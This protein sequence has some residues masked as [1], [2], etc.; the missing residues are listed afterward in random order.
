MKPK[1]FEGRGT[2]EIGNT[3]CVPDPISDPFILSL[4]KDSTSNTESSWIACLNREE[5]TRKRQRPR[6][7]CP[8]IINNKICVQ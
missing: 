3:L 2:C 7:F 1:G 8:T 5:F 4:L 6:S